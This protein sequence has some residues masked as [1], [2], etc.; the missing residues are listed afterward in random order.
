MT[1]TID[2]KKLKLSNHYKRDNKIREQIIDSIVEG[3][4]GQIVK[5]EWYKGAYRC[6]T[7]TGLIFIVSPE[8]DMILTY[9]L[10]RGGVAQGMFNHKA[11]GYLMKKINK[12]ANKYKEVMGGKLINSKLHEYKMK[13]IYYG[14]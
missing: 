6:L 14:R 11:P 2:L 9:Y 4:W 8:K 13:G 7:D 5:Q 12:N 1:I 10:A 3:N